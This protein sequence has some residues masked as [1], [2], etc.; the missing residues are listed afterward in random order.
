MGVIAYELLAGVKPFS[1]FTEDYQLGFETVAISKSMRRLIQ[2]LLE[3]VEDRRA[4][5]GEA[6]RLLEE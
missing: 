1:G 5:V 6:L 2:R 3:P 4:T